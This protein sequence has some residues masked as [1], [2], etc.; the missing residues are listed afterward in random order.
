[1]RMAELIEIEL[2]DGEVILAEVTI[3]D[4]DVGALDR[5]NLHGVSASAAR[6]GS[7]IHAALLKAMPMSPH[8]IGIDIGLKLAVKS[9]VLTSVLA[10]AS[11]EASVTVRLD[12]DVSDV[13]SR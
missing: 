13:R 7:I 3:V 5:F 4:S 12:W 1:M 11:G 2:P 10:E 8:R 9:G 6:I